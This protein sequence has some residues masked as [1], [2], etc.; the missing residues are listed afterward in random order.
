MVW[1]EQSMTVSV[2]VFSPATEWL[3]YPRTKVATQPNGTLCPQ[4]VV[5]RSS[6]F[7]ETLCTSH[8][9]SRSCWPSVL[10]YFGG[11]GLDLQKKCLLFIL[12]NL[13]WS[14]FLFGVLA[15]LQTGHRL[16]THTNTHTRCCVPKSVQC[17]AK[18][19]GKIKQ[20]AQTRGGGGAN[21]ENLL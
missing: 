3:L 8:L 15:D 11:F 16:H 12:F 5:W 9:A 20:Q 17:R 6:S 4:K 18:D 13:S 21:K 10:G 1:E 7:E 19:H 2:S 14:C